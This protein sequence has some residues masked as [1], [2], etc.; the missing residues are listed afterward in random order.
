MLK[1]QKREYSKG[2][3][4]IVYYLKQSKRT[5]KDI[6]RVLGISQSSAYK[7]IENPYFLTY[8]QLLTLSAYFNTPFIEFVNMVHL[9][10]TKLNTKDKL[11]LLDIVL[12]TNE[13]QKTIELV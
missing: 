12:K 8:N 6:Q 3:K 10:K 9:N 5:I 11:T 13:V 7:Y 4:A 2:N 1:G